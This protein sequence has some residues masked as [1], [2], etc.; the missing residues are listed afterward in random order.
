MNKYYS[1]GEF[2]R[3]LG[4]SSQ[5]LRNWEDEGKLKPHHKTENGYRYYTKEQLVQ[6]KK[7]M[8][9]VEDMSNFN[10]YEMNLTNHLANHETRNEYF[11]IDKLDELSQVLRL[12]KHDMITLMNT[13]GSDRARDIL[14]INIAHGLSKQCEIVYVNLTKSNVELEDMIVTNYNARYDED[15]NELDEENRKKY[16][17]LSKTRK[18]MYVLNECNIDKILEF[19]RQR[20][21]DTKDT[22]AVF[23]DDINRVTDYEEFDGV[24]RKLR[25]YSTE[26]NVIVFNISKYDIR[27][28]LNIYEDYALFIDSSEKCIKVCNNEKREEKYI[29]INCLKEKCLIYETKRSMILCQSSDGYIYDIKN[30]LATKINI[31]GKHDIDLELLNK[32]YSLLGNDMY[33]KKIRGEDITNRFFSYKMTDLYK[34]IYNTDKCTEENKQE[35]VNKINS[36]GGI[37][38]CVN[39]REEISILEFVSYTNDEIIT[40]ASPY[41]EYAV[42]QRWM[43]D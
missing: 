2:A 12:Q 4:V 24:V 30:E 34:Y 43:H 1:I 35:L 5:T 19:V 33:N 28:S 3:M 31:K 32:F 7:D 10:Y 8:G 14:A 37:R 11:K 6:Y 16:F 29:V 20:N 13:S 40:I 25:E 42:E 39:N 26:N 15:F 21:E 18:K 41:F 9:G 38:G 36:F 22:V 27:E 17:L 23:I